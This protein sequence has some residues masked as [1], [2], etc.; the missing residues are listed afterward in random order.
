M[1]QTLSK[2]LLYKCMGWKK[3]VRFK[4]PKKA[5]ICLAP[6]TSNW[7]FLIGQLYAEAEGLRG[8]FLMKK[9]WFIGPLGLFFRK[10]GGIPV[11]RDKHTSMTDRLAEMAKEVDK[12]QLCI[13][14]EGTRSLNSNWKMG[15]YYI[16]KKANLPI[17]LYGLDYERKLIACTKII[18]PSGDIDTDIQ[19][20]KSYFKDFKGKYPELFTVGEIG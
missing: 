15:F 4:L 16:A 12:F 9:E 13:T 14:P 6:H 19:D 3:D 18:N 7:D 5:I 10:L 8:N 11:Y 20:I 1:L 2:F 17:F